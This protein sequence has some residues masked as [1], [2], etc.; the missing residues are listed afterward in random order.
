MSASASAWL[1]VSRRRV[2]FTV[3]ELLVVLVLLALMALLSAPFVVRSVSIDRP[4]TAVEAIAGAC[5]EA[6]ITRTHVVRAFQTTDTTYAIACSSSG[7]A[8]HELRDILR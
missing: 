4:E 6:V 3:L 7:V 2:A 8:V 1:Q 5:R